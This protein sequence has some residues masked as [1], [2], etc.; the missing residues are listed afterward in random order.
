MRRKGCQKIDPRWLVVAVQEHGAVG[1]AIGALVV[2]ALLTLAL[3]GVSADTFFLDDS[4]A[5]ADG[6]RR[7]LEQIGRWRRKGL[8]GMRL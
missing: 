7:G 3:F 2:S 1:L 6:E 8:G 4:S 5:R